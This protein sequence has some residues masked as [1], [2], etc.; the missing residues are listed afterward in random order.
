MHGLKNAMQN[1]AATKPILRNTAAMSA[2]KFH[3]SFN[4]HDLRG[5]AKFLELLLGTKPVEL[6]SDYAKFELLEPALV[7]SLAPTDIPSA[8]G[9]NHVGFRLASRQSLVDLQQ[10][11]AAAGVPHDF[12]ESVAC[13]HSRQTKF[14]THDPAGNLWELYVLD[15]PSTATPELSML[16]PAKKQPSIALPE[17]SWAHRLGDS[18]P[19]SV[20]AA[21][22]SLDEVVL[23]GTF[24]ALLPDH[25]QEFILQEIARALRAG[26][27]LSIRGLT[28]DRALDGPPQLPGPAKMVEYVPTTGELLLMVQAAGFVD[29]ELT[30]FGETYSFHHAG[31]ELR[32]TK[33]LAWK[34]LVAQGSNHAVIYRGPFRELKDDS[35]RIFRRGERTNIDE[36]AYRR[37]RD[38]HGSQ[39]FVFLPEDLEDSIEKCSVSAT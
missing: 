21:D 33:L 18:F 6:H 30:T 36:L 13:C 3:L 27:K 1:M 5:T 8:A 22:E 26:G 24:D 39:H 28:A 19:D 14:W 12:E 23:E 16:T 17:A 7:L 20:P 9:L 4:V 11:L 35:G 38:S 29:L 15:E 2:T 32:E 37:L 25:R 31:T 10:R 34:P